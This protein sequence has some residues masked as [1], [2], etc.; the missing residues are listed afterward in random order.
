MKYILIVVATIFIGDGEEPKQMRLEL[1]Q[2]SYEECLT[3]KKD[4]KL[5]V[6]FPFL[7]FEIKSECIAEQTEPS[8]SIKT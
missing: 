3:A 7:N 5:E 4:F 8:E 2:E 1:P 6:P